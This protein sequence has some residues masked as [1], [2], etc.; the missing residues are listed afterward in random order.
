MGIDV[1][2]YAEGH[3]PDDRLAEAS[4]Y[5]LARC[6]IVDTFDGKWPVLARENSYDRPRVVLSTM[7]RY[8]GPGYERGDWPSIYGA[9]RL[10]RAALPECRVFYGGDSSEDGQECTDEFLSEMWDHFLGPHGDDY[11]RDIRAQNEA[12]SKC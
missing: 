10:L 6:S 7:S 11:R 8:Y 1:N 9:I 5:L 4:A 3:V 12:R 2:L